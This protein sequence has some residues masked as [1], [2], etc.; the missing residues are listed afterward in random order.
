MTMLPT[1][2]LILLGQ[3]GYAS[4]PLPAIDAALA[5][6]QVQPDDVVLDI[7]CGDGRVCVLAAKRYGCRAIGIELDANLA[8]LA[9]RTVARNRVRG[10]EIRHEDAL[11]ADLSAATVVYVYHQT[12]F[13]DA[14]RPQLERLKPKTRVVFLDHAP[15]WLDLSPART[16]ATDQHTHKL[17]L[18]T[19]GACEGKDPMIVSVGRHYPGVR[20]FGGLREPLLVELAQDCADRLASNGEAAYWR[21]GHPGWDGRFHRIRSRLGVSAVE[22]SAFSWPNPSDTL[23][24]EIVRGF[25]FDWQRSSGHWAVVSAPHARF[26]EGVAKSRANIWYGVVITAD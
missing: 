7:G 15:T 3:S 25:F 20:C 1:L 9:E 22:V 13:L 19:V 21:D 14:L 24:V 11:Q 8:R 6:A 10:V 23:T 17:Y 4:S 26:G 18:W 2:L 5:V 16:L 12:K